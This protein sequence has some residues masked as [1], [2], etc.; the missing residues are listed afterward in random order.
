M[1]NLY[2]K[3]YHNKTK[4]D[5]KVTFKSKSLVGNQLNET[6]ICNET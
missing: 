3:I 5:F 2:P 6:Y 4:K 1:K